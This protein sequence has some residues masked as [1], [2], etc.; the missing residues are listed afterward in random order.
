MTYRLGRLM[1]LLVL[2]FAQTR[3]LPATSGSGERPQFAWQTELGNVYF[4][5]WGDS[6]VTCITWGIEYPNKVSIP[7]SGWI[8]L[9]CASALVAAFFT[10]ALYLLWRRAQLKPPTE[11]AADG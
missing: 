10:L 6:E 8:S 1:L 3:S 7:L 11:Q 4:A 5:V 9:T 2:L